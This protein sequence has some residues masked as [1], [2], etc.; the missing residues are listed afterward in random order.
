MIKLLKF[1]EHAQQVDENLFNF[2]FGIN[3]VLNVSKKTKIRERISV[4]QITFEFLNKKTFSHDK[5]NLI[6]S[7]NLPIR[8][9]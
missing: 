4:S 5:Y 8:Q 7:D 1:N 6:F 3:R 9:T 2:T